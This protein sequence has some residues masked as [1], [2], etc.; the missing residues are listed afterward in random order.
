MTDHRDVPHGTDPEPCWYCSGTGEDQR[1]PCPCC[2]H[3]EHHTTPPTRAVLHFR[4]QEW[5][6]I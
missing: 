6:T 5:M 4:R 1:Q 3:N 2:Q